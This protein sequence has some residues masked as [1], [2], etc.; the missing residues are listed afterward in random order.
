[1]LEVLKIARNK[2]DYTRDHKPEIDECERIMTIISAVTNAADLVVRVEEVIKTS[3][4]LKICKQLSSMEKALADLPATSVEYGAGP[5][6]ICL[7]REGKMLRYK[8]HARLK[9]LFSSCIQLEAG[10]ISVHKKIRG[11]VRGEET[12]LDKPVSILDILSSLDATGDVMELILSLLEN[13]WTFIISPIWKEKKAMVPKLS[14]GDEFSE[15]FLSSVASNSSSL[16]VEANR[17]NPSD[18]FS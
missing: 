1:M 15:L 7:R 14:M 18:I 11:L 10:R 2:A 6:C 12:P 9:L 16:T 5:A 3:D 17:G 13:I 4:L 8:F